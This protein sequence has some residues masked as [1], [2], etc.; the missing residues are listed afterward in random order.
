MKV[1]VAQQDEKAFEFAQREF[2]ALNAARE[3]YVDDV[4]AETELRTKISQ[5]LVMLS[6]KRVETLPKKHSTI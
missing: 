6:S 3:G 1:P 4:V 5:A 2:S